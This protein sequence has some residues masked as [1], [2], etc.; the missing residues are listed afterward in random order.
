MPLGY[1]YYAS[2]ISLA[3]NF[4]QKLLDRCWR[5]SG[6]LLY[7]PNQRDSCCPHYT[8]RLDSSKFKPSK[9]QRQA[10]NRFNKFVVGKS[11]AEEAAR[12]YPR[13]REDARKR[14]NEF[15]LVQR[16]HESETPWL[17]EPPEP[18]HR[19]TV[20][21]EPDTF[22]EEKY[23]VFENYQRNVH[24]E[25]PEKITPTGFKRFL[26][27]SPLRRETFVDAD[28][29]SRELGS[30]HQCYRLDG[31]LLAIGVLDLLPNCV[32]AVYFLYHDSIHMHSPGKLG[33]LREIALAI[34]GGYRW[35]YS[36]YYIH[37][38]PKMRYKIDYS[39]QYVLD[40]ESLTWDLLDEAALSIFDKK[41]Y[42]SLSRERAG[43][44]ADAS[45][46]VAMEE[47]SASAEPSRSMSEGP[48]DDEKM[49]EDKA[50][51]AEDRDAF[52]LTSNMPGIP[53]LEEMLQVNMDNLPILFDNAKRMFRVSDLVMWDEEEVDDY[54][55]LKSRIAE[56]VAAIGPDLMDEICIDFRRKQSQL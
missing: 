8:L 55:S 50:E 19:L 48:P 39:P 3:P 54:G 18:A 46:E 11:Y 34:E 6:K 16:I 1:S 14:D 9:D 51:E 40:P 29:K 56:L 47:A 21:L 49:G 36:G 24:K 33:A 44:E 12:L 43:L 31:Q 42:V 4:Y 7:R 53:S 41:P 26:C 25:P 5:R 17:K 22:T 38:C 10:V 52:L 27:D 45:S 28:G 35:W 30:F 32:S 2:A 20:S 13:A 15:N 23:S 37:S